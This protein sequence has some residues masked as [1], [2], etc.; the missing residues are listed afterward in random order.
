[1]DEG[2]HVALIFQKDDADD[3]DDNNNN[4]LLCGLLWKKMCL[5]FCRNVSMQC[6]AAACS[7]IRTRS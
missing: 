3:D 6:T 4:G 5:M 7:K 2:E 1:M